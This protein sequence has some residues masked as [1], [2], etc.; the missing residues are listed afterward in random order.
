MNDR[1]QEIFDKQKSLQTLLTEKEHPGEYPE[2]LPGHI[3]GLMSEL[4]EILAEHQGWKHWKKNKK[5]VVWENVKEEVV[6]AFHYMINIALVLKMDAD[7]LYDG[8]IKKNK[9]NI[10][11]QNSNY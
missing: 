2:L 6:D 9:E 11:R 10:E 3:T 5:E 7:D 1:F 4:G 8:F